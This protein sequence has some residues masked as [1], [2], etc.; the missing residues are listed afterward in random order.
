LEYRLHTARTRGAPGWITTW[1][2]PREFHSHTYTLLK[3]QLLP[4][5]GSHAEHKL[6]IL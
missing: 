4:A 2:K 6:L 5:F 1:C 3:K